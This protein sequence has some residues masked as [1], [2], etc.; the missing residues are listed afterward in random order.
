M[1]LTE[2]WR[3]AIIIALQKIRKKSGYVPVHIEISLSTPLNESIVL[4]ESS[5]S[6]K[7]NFKHKGF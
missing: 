4:N 2:E 5:N 6:V 7:I 3:V 1:K